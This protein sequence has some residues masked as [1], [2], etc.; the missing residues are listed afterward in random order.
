MP[1]VSSGY[2][3]SPGYTKLKFI[4]SETTSPTVAD[5]NAAVTATR[6]LLATFATSIPNAAKYAFQNPCQWFSN[7]GVLLGEIVSTAAPADISGTGGTTF[8]GGVGAVIF[9]NTGALN[10]GHKVR[11]RT[12]VVPLST[13]AF[14]TDGT[15]QSALVANVTTA[16]ATYL[17]TNPPPAVNSRKLDQADRGD[18]TYAVTSAV[19]KDRSAFLRS[20]RV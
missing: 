13:N 7:A 18:A 1:W 2:T 17:G 14:S 20:R 15:L 12:Y 3:G 11:G 4:A 19:I 10:G 16:L 6:V 8:P 9:W 5:V